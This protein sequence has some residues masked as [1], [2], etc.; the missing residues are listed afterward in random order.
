MEKTSLCTQWTS[1]FYLFCYFLCIAFFTQNVSG[2]EWP[3]MCWCAVKKLLAQWHLLNYVDREVQQPA[4]VQRTNVIYSWQFLFQLFLAFV[5][6]VFQHFCLSAV[7]SESSSCQSICILSESRLVFCRLC[8]AIH[9]SQQRREQ[10]VTM[11]A[12]I[13]S[14]HT[15]SLIFYHKSAHSLDAI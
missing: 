3:F 11:P 13:T 8:T 1:Y 12:D 10:E 4:A 14:Q 9:L 2:A 7:Y 5:E 15:K 6:P